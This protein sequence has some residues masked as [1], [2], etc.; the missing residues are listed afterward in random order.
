MRNI[1]NSVSESDVA[2]TA[3]LT[4]RLERER[5]ARLAAEAI[6][7]AGLRDLYEKQREVRLLQMIAAAANEASAVE[8]AVQVAL[9]EVCA[10]AGWPVGHAYL[11]S[12]E[13]PDL[14]V[15]TSLWHLDDA[16]RFADFRR[17]TEATPMP[18]GVG[19][20]GRILAT[21]KPAW[22]IDV[23][24]DDNFPRA[25]HAVDI[26]VRA[27]FG[28]P[29]LVGTQV[30]GVLEFFVE[31]PSEPNTRLLEL[32]GHIGA[33]LGRVV[34]RQRANEA[35]RASNRR[36]EET[37][38]QLK[39][40]EQ[41]VV[42][43]ERLRALGQMASGVAHDFNNALSAVVGLSNL[44]LLRPEM[45]EDKAKLR[46]N[47][48]LIFTAGEDAT[49]VVRRLREFYRQ[50]EDDEVFSPVSMTELATTAVSLTEPRWKGQ[51]QAAGATIAVETAFDAVPP[52]NGNAAE[53]REVLTNLIFNAVDAMPRGGT[54]TL[55]TR[56]DPT[57]EWVLTE[58]TDTGVGM[59]EEVRRRC[60]EPFFSTKGE[61]GTGLGL[62]MVFGIIQRHEGS[63]D[64]ESERGRGTTFR[65]GLRVQKEPAA[66]MTAS[67][68]ESGGR[69]LRIL[70]V[71]DDAVPREVA[72][73]CLEADGHSVETATNGQEA[74]EKFQA[75]WFDVVV[76]DR[77]MPVMNGVILA[78]TI[79]RLAPRKPA[80]IMLTGFGE[81]MS[82]AGE[83]PPG[84]D[85]VVS[86][87][88]TLSKIREA[89]KELGG[90]L[91][92]PL[93]CLPQDRIA[94]A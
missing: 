49:H 25:R 14:L 11:A 93:R 68:S 57:G 26:G 52:V 28:F 43:Q 65:V 50:R 15:S 70:V 75:G 7:E 48:E 63:L 41:Q 6:A 5:K 69:P 22:I 8:A 45:T 71:D 64:I 38:A 46:R 62:A 12:A 72:V 80:I 76:T 94:R 90:G 74:L 54:L 10:H 32:M 36:L 61:R 55:R 77:A 82:A 73:A 20:P 29:V 42:Q 27:A 1:L 39:D 31:T 34:E 47:L 66:G 87:P 58:V 81:L 9:D 83:R 53:L 40:K 78:A 92:G 37:L 60:L 86:K 35:L 33:Q 59:S 13:R 2:V 79:K 23:T 19:L 51:A 56:T 91:D 16:E 44:M 84:V 88:V 21:G 4:R 24:K 30:G 89:L 17:I 3:R 18:T 85:L 67:L